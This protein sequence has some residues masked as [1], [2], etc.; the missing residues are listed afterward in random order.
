[1]TSRERVISGAKRVTV[2]RKPVLCWPF[3]SEESDIRHFNHESLPEEVSEEPGELTLVE[4]TN[5]FGLAMQRGVDLNRELKD[6]P[7]SGNCLLGDFCDEAQRDIDLAMEIGADGIIYRLYGA[8][9]QHCTPMQYGGYYL[10]RDRELLDKVSDA[11]LNIL[12]VVGEEDVYLDFVSDLP[13]NVFGWDVKE[14][15][16]EPNAVREM[17]TGALL[18]EH[19]DCD[20]LL[21]PGTAFL[22]RVLES[23]L[24]TED[25]YAI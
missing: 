2:D 8:R 10:E 13:A 6:D 25:S 9:A 12:F 1:M 14:S 3:W 18:G 21:R 17:R 16:I 15:K 4:I 24:R 19:P 7:R 22:S 5:P 23:S 20:I 11:V